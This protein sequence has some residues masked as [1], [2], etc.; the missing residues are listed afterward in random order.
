[1]PTELAPDQLKLVIESVLF[2][3]DGPVELRTLARLTEQT[4]EA[5]SQ[6]LEE[7]GATSRERG[8]RIQRT[9]Q[10]AQMVSAP[11][12][13][14]Y[15]QRYLGIDENQRLSPVVLVTLTVIA[16]KQPVTKGEVER[17]L[18]KNCDYSVMVLKA[19]DLINEVG[20]T[21][22]PGRPYLYGTTFKFLEHFG[23]EK[24]EDLPPLPELEIAA[25][26][27]AENG[28]GASQ[29]P[30]PDTDDEAFAEAEMPGA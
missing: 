25:A 11:E 12:T 4:P 27:V 28:N 24:P 26:L 14:S 8:V 23:L 30:L 6:A 1:M 9:G 18:R 10:S 15:V 3:A 17:I 20:R 29:E 13:A 2:V 19:R 5:I 16:Y 7:L 22:G 21:D